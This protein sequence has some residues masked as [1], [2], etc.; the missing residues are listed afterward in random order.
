MT[1]AVV[2]TEQEIDNKEPKPG[3]LFTKGR[4]CGRTYDQ[5]YDRLFHLVSY[6]RNMSH[7]RMSQITTYLQLSYADRKPEIWQIIDNYATYTHVI[8][9]YLRK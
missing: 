9:I 5:S 6:S 1:N 7:V 2:L 8:V 4:K 3:V